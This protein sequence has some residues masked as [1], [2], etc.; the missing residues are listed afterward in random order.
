MLQVC[1]KATG[2]VAGRSMVR[3]MIVFV[4]TVSTL[5]ISVGFDRL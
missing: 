5:P 2:L 1:Q 3:S 4:L